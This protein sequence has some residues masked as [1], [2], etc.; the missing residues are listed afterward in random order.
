M[1][2]TRSARSPVHRSTGAPFDQTRACGT[3][4][5]RPPPRCGRTCRPASTAHAAWRLEAMILQCCTPIMATT[6]AHCTH[7]P[8][9]QRQLAPRA[10]HHVCEIDVHA[11][12]RLRPQEGVRRLIG[13]QCRRR[14]CNGARCLA[15]S[16][17]GCCRVT[18]A[19]RRSCRLVTGH[20]WPHVRLKQ[21]VKHARRLEAI[22]RTRGAAP[23]AA[24]AQRV[25]H[26]AHLVQREAGGEG[27]VFEDALCQ[28]HPRGILSGRASCAATTTGGGGGLGRLGGCLLRLGNH[29]LRRRL[30]ELVGSASS[31]RS[32]CGVQCSQSCRSRHSAGGTAPSRATPPHDGSAR[33]HR[34][35]LRQLLHSVSGSTNR[36][37]CP[38]ASQTAGSVRNDG[39]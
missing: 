21:Q 33:T 20:G 38:D 2:R 17:A 3:R 14:S 13:V 4:S 35:R 8:D 29:T 6:A 34:T 11:L 9:A 37:T 5:C 7:L 15:G 23:R 25:Q 16:T 22:A 1:L 36:E 24:G 26:L 28:S 39:R 10:V 31:G 12:C 32:A 27:R 30:Q 18:A 19:T